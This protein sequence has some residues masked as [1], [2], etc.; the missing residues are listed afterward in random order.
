MPGVALPS[1]RSGELATDLLATSR[2]RATTSSS[3]R[4]DAAFTFGNSELRSQTPELTLPFGPDAARSQVTKE[5]SASGSAAVG[6][7]SVL[8]TP[9]V[10]SFCG[11][12]GGMLAD[13][14]VCDN[15]RLPDTRT[16]LR[17]IG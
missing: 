3:G 11:L 12:N 1:A 13:T 6:A 9:S 8:A 17:E 2:T 15:E 14:S 5:T 16:K 7:S 10:N 4:T